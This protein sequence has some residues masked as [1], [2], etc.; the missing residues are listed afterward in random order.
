MNGLKDMIMT[1]RAYLTQNQDRFTVMKDKLL[2]EHKQRVE[3]SKIDV[4]LMNFI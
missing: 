4:I 1:Y 3:I 2:A